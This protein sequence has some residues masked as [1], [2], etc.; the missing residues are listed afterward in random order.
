MDFRAEM[1]KEEKEPNFVFHMDGSAHY[2]NKVT[3]CCDIFGKTCS[4]GG[5]MHYQPVYGGYYYQCEECKK[6]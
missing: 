3:G 5:F 6:T 4:C 1:E 2:K